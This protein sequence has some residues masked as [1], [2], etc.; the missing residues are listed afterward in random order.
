VYL[1]WQSVAK[2]WAE[3][4]M[5]ERFEG[6]AEVIMGLMDQITDTALA[7]VRKECKE[8]IVTLDIHLTMSFT[9]LLDSLLRPEYQVCFFFFTRVTGPR[10]SLSLKLSVYEHQIRAVLASCGYYCFRVLKPDTLNPNPPTQVTKANW[11]E[12][13]PKYLRP[14]KS[15]NSLSL[16]HTHHTLTHTLSHTR[17]TLSLSLHD[18]G[19]EGQLAGDAAKVLCLFLLLDHRRQPPGNPHLLSSSLLLSSL[20][21]SATQSL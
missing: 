8:H 5:E 13:L 18:A 7:F 14:R 10:R 3:Y 19:D 2:S 12:M 21:L 15:I 17:S 11:Q 1:P 20:E 16:T 6:S 4:V 9:K